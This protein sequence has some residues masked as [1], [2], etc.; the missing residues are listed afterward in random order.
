VIHLALP[1]ALALLPAPLVIWLL[2]PPYR[3]R[4]AAVRTPFFRAVAAAT[5]HAPSAGAVVP[6]RNW[7]QWLIAPVAWALVVLAAARPVWIDPPIEQVQAARDLL[8]AVDL[9]GSMDTRDM[10]DAA[11][12]R[13]DRLT[14]VKQVLGDFIDRR[15]GDRIGLI[16]FGESAYLQAPFTLDHAVVRQLLD[17]TAVRMAGPRTMIGDAIGLGIKTFAASTSDERVL[18]LLTDGNDTG[19]KMPPARAAAIAADHGVTIHAIA[20]GDP[21]TAG[22]DQLDV[23]ALDAIVQPTG[24][25]VFLAVDRAGLVQVYRELDQLVPVQVNV[26]SY[27]PTTP[28]YHWPLGAALTLLATFQIAMLLGHAL[29][30]LALRHA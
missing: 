26:T 28:L 2:L 24:G 8:L 4:R 25:R 29:R 11:G 3:E 6:R 22:E 12:G 10:T 27:R 20:M 9:S 13:V 21:R 15:A 16:V 23:A 7:L 18:I 17:E 14:A 19:S 5:G 30:R 1:W